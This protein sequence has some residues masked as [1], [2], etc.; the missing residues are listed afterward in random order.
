MKFKLTFAPTALRSWKSLPRPVQVR[1]N[2]VF[3]L[4]EHDPRRATADLDV[5]QLYGYQNVWTV[6]IPA[7]RG[8]YAIEGA[9]VVMVIFGHRDSIYSRLHRL[10]PP[11]RQHVSRMASNRPE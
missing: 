4:L 10:I 2:E 1:F 11:S 3:D 8:I 6:R 9:E 5:H 7:Y